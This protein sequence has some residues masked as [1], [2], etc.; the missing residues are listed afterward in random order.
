MAKSI[1]VGFVFSIDVSKYKLFKSK[2]DS[3]K[4]TEQ[5]HDKYLFDS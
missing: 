3:S 5:T 4:K 2:H 1:K